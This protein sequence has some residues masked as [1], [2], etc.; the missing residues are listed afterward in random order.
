MSSQ[1]QPKTLLLQSGGIDSTAAALNLLGAGHKVVALTL[2]KNAA[3]HTHL[4]RIRALEIRSKYKLYAWG[5]ADISAWDASLDKHVESTVNDPVPVSCLT[6]ILAKITAAVPYCHKH[7]LSTMAL[8]Y[9]DYQSS[10]AEQTSHAINQQREELAQLGISLLL[11]S[12]HYKAKDEV[13]T[14]LIARE[15]NPSSLEN[16]CCIGHIGT[17]TT[18]PHLILQVVTTAFSFL[19]Q[20]KPTMAVVDTVGDFPA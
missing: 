7:E 13:V 2:A 9:T 17:Q 19:S 15:M 6:C 1:H 3:E 18:P 20:N 14:D 16:P 10:W 5:M 12:S 11:P 8:G 4:P